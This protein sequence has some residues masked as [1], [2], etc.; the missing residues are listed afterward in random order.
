[1]LRLCDYAKIYDQDEYGLWVFQFYDDSGWN[2][3]RCPCENNV[4]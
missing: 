2:Y 1:M 4:L 3:Y